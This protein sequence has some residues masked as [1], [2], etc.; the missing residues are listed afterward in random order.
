MALANANTLKDDHNEMQFN[1]ITKTQNIIGLQYIV[2]LNGTPSNYQSGS[3][4]NFS[5]QTKPA[6]FSVI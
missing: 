1:I 2:F 3:T 4:L 6:V 5:D